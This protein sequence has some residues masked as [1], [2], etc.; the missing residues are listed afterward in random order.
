[1][2]NNWLNWTIIVLC[3]IIILLLSISQLHKIFQATFKGNRFP[4]LGNSTQIRIVHQLQEACT[5]MSADGTGA[6]I[7]LE[8]NTPLEHLRTDGHI[9]DANISS[10]LIISIFSKNSPLHDGALIIKN[11]KI[12][13]AGTFYKISR[14]SISNK[15][16][17]RHRA[18]VGISEQSDSLTIVVSEETGII[19]F[20]RHGKIKKISINDFQEKLFE[21]LK[22]NRR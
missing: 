19:S 14:S 21:F 18:A 3:V 8:L 4:K 11:S 15:Y 22:D 12:K 20:C 16:G 5:Q 6:L 1:M 7:T 10:S 17:A 2:H 13:Y 9:L